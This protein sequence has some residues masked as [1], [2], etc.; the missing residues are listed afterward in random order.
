[1]R[2]YPVGE[3]RGVEIGE[4][5]AKKDAAQSL[6]D[7]GLACRTDCQSSQS[8]F[9]ACETVDFGRNRIGEISLR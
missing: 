4:M 8:Q 5:R 7:M 9:A 3:Q 6:A 1:M 2:G